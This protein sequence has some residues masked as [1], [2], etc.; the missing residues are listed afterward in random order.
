MYEVSMRN[1]DPRA[2]RSGFVPWVNLHD[3]GELPDL[4]Y[5]MKLM[6]FPHNDI[7]G[8]KRVQYI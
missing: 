2:R 4:S 1:S 6:S 5:K 3:L 7:V 8:I